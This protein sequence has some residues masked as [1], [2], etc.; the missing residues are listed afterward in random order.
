MFDVRRLT[1]SILAAAATIL[2]PHVALA[3][4]S[5]TIRMP[6][7]DVP[8]RSNRET[9]TFVPVRSRQPVNVTDIVFNNLASKASFSTHHAIAFVYT[10]DLASLG[11]IERHVVD[12]PICLNFGGGDPGKLQ[13][14]ALAQGPRARFPTPSG[15]AVRLMPGKL[16]SGKSAL[17]LIINAHW[18]NGTDDV[19][20]ARATVKLVL[21]KNR[22]VK[23]YL[24]PIFDSVASATIKVPPGETGSVSYRWA[25]GN[26][27]LSV[28]S[29][30]GGGAL[31]PDGPAC[32]T[33]LTSHMHRRGKL[34]TIDFVRQGG[35]PTRL[36]ENTV[37]TDPPV[38]RF[39]PPLL[40]R[41]GDEI[42]YAC[43]HDNA[44]DTRLGCEEVAGQTPGRSLLE[45]I[46]RT[47]GLRFDGSARLCRVPGPNAQECPPGPDPAHPD[48]TL[49]GNCV[50]ANLVFGFLSEDEMCL[51][52]G[53]YYDADP[54][55]APGH[56]CDL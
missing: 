15:T 44:T 16:A 38:A 31:P 54:A 1:L 17:G 27:G 3:R 9:C 12:D 13:V 6:A 55:A 21:A 36:L 23:R 20:R 7:F 50:L 42:R 11:D 46:A 26:P 53:S 34:F 8:P 10:G 28:F 51:L 47:G 35:A 4:R 56:E 22:A 5:I 29:R 24:N 19:Q 30:F 49:T 45:E 40:V 2:A 25:P 37:Y 41:V 14:L 18:I 32:V 48:R 52:P 39:D 33:F 43:V